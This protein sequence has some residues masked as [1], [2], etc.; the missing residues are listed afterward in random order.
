M[1]KKL[2]RWM[3]DLFAAVLSSGSCGNSTLVFHDGSGVLID[4]GMSCREMEQRLSAFGVDAPQI[5]A[6]VLT[7]EHTD[8]TRG[9]RRFCRE[10]GLPLLATRGTLAL[11]P[12]EGVR[13]EAIAADKEFSLNGL[14]IRP[15][16]VRHLAAEPV[17]ISIVSDEKKIAIATDLGS[18]TREVQR[19]M[20]GADLMIVESNY[21]RDML[22]SGTY[23]DFLKR[24]IMSDHGHLSNDD[25]GLLIAKAASE[26]TNAVVL[27]HLSKDNNTPERARNAT[28]SRLPREKRRL[29]VQVAEHGA[30]CGPFR[31]G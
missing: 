19:E 21:D 26:K 18:V 28:A 9:A 25:A 24:A 27:A 17:A 31:L 13:T 14:R 1:T 20:S 12:L 10:H 11:T 22:E 2:R 23:P 7:H 29:G 4:A 5:E 8:H 30:M 15:F 16:R 6:V 3:H